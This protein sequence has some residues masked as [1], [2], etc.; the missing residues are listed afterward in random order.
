MELTYF[1]NLQEAVRACV[2]AFM[3]ITKSDKLPQPLKDGQY[4]LEKTQKVANGAVVR[5]RLL[6]PDFNAAWGP[7]AVGWLLEVAAMM[8]QRVVSSEHTEYSLTRV[9]QRELTSAIETIFKGMVKKWNVQDQTEAKV[10]E[11]KYAD[12]LKKRKRMV[13]CH[14]NRRSNCSPCV[15][16]VEGELSP[17]HRREVDRSHHSTAP[18]AASQVRLPMAI[19]VY[20]SHG[21]GGITRSSAGPYRPYN[22]R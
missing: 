18:R 13:S 6:R 16:L 20:R 11:K 4:W 12:V 21:V 9:T 2:Y 5:Q 19:P 15:C 1:D 22:N 17:G 7:N 3:G 10:K 14:H 8:K